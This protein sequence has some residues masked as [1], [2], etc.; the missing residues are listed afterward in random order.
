ME[1]KLDVNRATLE[2]LLVGVPLP[3]S[4]RR[5]LEYARRQ[6]RAGESVPLLERIPDRDYDTLQD[7]GEV[8]E[9]RQVA[10]AGTEAPVPRPES[11]RPPGGAA[12]V[13]GDEEP[14]NVLAARD[15]E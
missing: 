13:G 14:A 3:A 15:A 12:Y 2:S 5:L 8:L 4:K 10:A 9:P 6:P 7:V 11:G 1:K